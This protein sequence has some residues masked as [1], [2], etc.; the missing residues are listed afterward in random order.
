MAPSFSIFPPTLPSSSTTLELSHDPSHP[1]LPNPC[2]KQLGRQGNDRAHCILFK[3][4]Q[5]TEFMAWWTT[6][7]WYETNK[8]KSIT[9]T[10]KKKYA[11]V[12]EHFEPAARLKDGEPW[13][14]CTRCDEV[15][16]HPSIKGIGSSTM[17]RHIATKGCLARAKLLGKTPVLEKAASRTL[18]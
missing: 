2:I 9:W 3:T 12:W 4:E 18:V 13:V 5:S 10:V 7:Q 6:T 1:S 14:Y 8:D 11:A 17:T 15:L 16:S